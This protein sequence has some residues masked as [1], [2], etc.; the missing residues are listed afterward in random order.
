M[1]GRRRPETEP[2]RLVIIGS[3][4]A[5]Y[6][7]CRSALEASTN[8]NVALI[9]R[10]IGPLYSPCVL[11]Y[12]LAGEVS[13]DRLFIPTEYGTGVDR[14]RFMMGTNAVGIDPEQKLVF[15]DREQDAV[16][17]DRLILAPGGRNVTPPI[18]GIDLAGVFHCKTLKDVDEL[19]AWP[20]KRAVVVG[21]GPIGLEVAAALN[22]RGMKVSVIEL[23][24]RLLPALL[25]ASPA[26]IVAE[27]LTEAGIDAMVGER[28]LSLAGRGRVKAVITDKRK[29]AADVVVLAAG[30]RPDIELARKAG[31]A[32][33]PT[34]GILIDNFLTTSDPHIWACGDCV[35]SLDAISGAS[36]LSM[37][38]SNAMVQGCVAGT[39]AAGGRRTYHGSS[40]SVTVNLFETFIF[41]LGS[42]S[43][44]LPGCAVTEYK[45]RKGYIRLLAKENRL[46]GVQIVGDDSWAGI[47]SVLSSPDMVKSLKAASIRSNHI[48]QTPHSHK[49]REMVAALID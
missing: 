21:S 41:S 19:T 46:V 33:G 32:I 47:T 12:Y 44:S 36:T 35:E 3:G 20:A 6:S 24:D 4:I 5:G 45:S 8:V 15:L 30:I 37:L 16:P 43:A 38:W 42:T 40:S 14:V 10:E 11:P 22:M 23:L 48:F 17:Y 34:G 7:A 1:T 13:R 28:V 2:L 18:E 25:D 31:I 27:T 29:I 39:N 9:T 49:L 26:M